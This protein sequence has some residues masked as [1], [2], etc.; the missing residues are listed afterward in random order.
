[1]PGHEGSAV[2][3]DSEGSWGPVIGGGLLLA[4]GLTLA[5]ASWAPA[6]AATGRTRNW[7]AR[8]AE[9]LVSE[10][11]EA[12]DDQQWVQPIVVYTYRVGDRDYLSSRYSF[13]VVRSFTQASAEAFVQ[14]YPA[15]RKVPCRVD[16][17]DPRQALL[18]P[19]WRPLDASNASIAFFSSLA[20]VIG[21]TVV[22]SALRR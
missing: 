5:I 11:G 20:V 18:D 17:N 10:V 13:F 14:R 4:A 6:L 19:D 7:P 8:E 2:T 9:I 21:L 3:G 1:M 16:P 15:G 22:V 12:G